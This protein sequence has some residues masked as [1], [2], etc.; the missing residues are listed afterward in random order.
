MSAAAISRWTG[1]T[2]M[3]QDEDKYRLICKVVMERDNWRCQHCG[4]MMNLQVHHQQFRS[5]GGPDTKDNLITLCAF[6][7]RL[8]HV[9]GP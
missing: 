1:E 3:T 2:S 8:T 5:H 9:G 6:C 4:S 7:H